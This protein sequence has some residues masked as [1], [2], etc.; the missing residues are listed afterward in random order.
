MQEYRSIELNLKVGCPVGCLYCPQDKFVKSNFGTKR[1]LSRADL[2]KILDNLTHGQNEAEVFFAAMSE[3]F[4][5]K[6]CVSLI[7]DCHNHELVTRVVVFTTG[8]H[9]TEEHIERLANFNKLKMNFHIGKKD[10]MPNFDERIWPKI[11]KIK[12]MIPKSEF[13]NVGFEKDNDLEMDLNK[14]GVE[15]K[16]QPIISRAGNLVSVGDTA[17]DSHF[18]RHPVTC[19]RVKDA[20]RP[21]ILPDGTALACA[22]DYSCELKIGNLLESTWKDLDFEKI[23]KL[24]TKPCDMPCFRGCHYAKK[25]PKIL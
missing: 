14:K 18:V 13:I 11:E 24:Q 1:E 6:E 2:T 23:I 25:E 15:L 20:K 3:P 21:V 4:S 9:L 8:Y 22:N 10:C 19:P 17:L 12:K 16:F 7:E 5:H